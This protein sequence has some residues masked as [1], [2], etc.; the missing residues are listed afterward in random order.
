MSVIGKGM[1]VAGDGAALAPVMSVHHDAKIITIT[2]G[3]EGA[4]GANFQH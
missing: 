2:K 1:F 4:T 3:F